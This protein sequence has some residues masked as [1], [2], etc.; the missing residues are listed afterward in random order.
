MQIYPA[1]GR[2]EI[3]FL[4]SRRFALDRIRYTDWYYL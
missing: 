3:Y 1:R 2:N 4:P